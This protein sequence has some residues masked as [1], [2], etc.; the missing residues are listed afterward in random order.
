MLATGGASDVGKMG[1]SSVYS[2]G[3]T[4]IQKCNCESNLLAA[5]NVNI[6]LESRN[7]SAN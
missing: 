3:K 7:M 1:S 2:L 6:A 5:G 4:K